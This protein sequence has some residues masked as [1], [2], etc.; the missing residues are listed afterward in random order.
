MVFFIRE[1]VGPTV[2]LPTPKTLFGIT[3]KMLAPWWLEGHVKE[4]YEISMAGEPDRMSI[5]FSPPSHLCAV[6]YISEISL[7]LTLS[8]HSTQLL[9]YFFQIVNRKNGKNCCR[10][11][12]HSDVKLLKSF[13]IDIFS[14]W[15]IFVGLDRR[16]P[17]IRYR[18][19]LRYIAIFS[20]CIAMI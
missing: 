14:N 1:E 20:H 18:I 9:F 6:I 3:V 17:Y 4:P 11:R 2:G 19:I 10:F 8:N 7:N 15:Y 12:L 16:Y 5:F 13:D